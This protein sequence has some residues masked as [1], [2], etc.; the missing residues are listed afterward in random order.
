MLGKLNTFIKHLWLDAAD[1]KR[2]IPADMLKRLAQRVAASERR[3]SGEIRICVEASLPMSYLWRLGKHHSIAQLTRQRA[4]TMFGKLRVWDTEHN[5]GVLIYVLLA[6]HAIEIVADRGVARHVSQA[7]WQAM[8]ARMAGAFRENRYED[9]LT[10]A[11][12]ETSALLMAHFAEQSSSGK[13]NELS[14]TPL[15]Q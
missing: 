12:E 3:H 11:L 8:V 2:A 1:T 13:P 10:Q 6:E 7:Q 15:L 4:V 5:N 9:G 14:D